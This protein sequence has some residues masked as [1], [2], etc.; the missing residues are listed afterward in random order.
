M[1]LIC[2]YFTASQFAQWAASA[3]TN[4]M[5]GSTLGAA[6][7]VWGVADA[8]VLLGAGKVVRAFPPT[9]S[10]FRSAALLLIATWLE[11]AW[12]LRMVF[13]AIG[14]AHCVADESTELVDV[15]KST[16]NG[17]DLSLNLLGVMLGAYNLLV[18]D[19][20]LA[21]QLRVCR[22]GLVR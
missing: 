4:S 18:D 22:R 12:T 2:Y 8:L 14:G 9:V 5:L 1:R 17:M 20:A 7:I 15:R 19:E 3:N 10:S 16:L 11:E 6:L 21:G 13:S